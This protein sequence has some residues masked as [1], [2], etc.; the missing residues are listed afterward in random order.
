M[1]A[2]FCLKATAVA[3]AAE[4]YRQPPHRGAPLSTRPSVRPAGRPAVR[5]SLAHSLGIFSQITVAVTTAPV[6]VEVRETSNDE[7]L[8][9]ATG[10]SAVATEIVAIATNLNRITRTKPN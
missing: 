2:G 5:P 4:S 8:I 10:V 3:A 1:A 9:T 6:V 7:R